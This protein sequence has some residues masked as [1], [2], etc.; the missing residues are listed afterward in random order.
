MIE[1]AYLP[2]PPRR[3]CGMFS[4]AVIHRKRLVSLSFLLFYRSQLSKLWVSSYLG[5][6]DVNGSFPKALTA[7]V[8]SVLADETGGMCADAAVKCSN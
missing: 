6:S 3:G 4:G 7:D 1:T 8:E 5:E 2:P